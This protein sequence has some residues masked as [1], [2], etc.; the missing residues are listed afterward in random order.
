MKS[1]T[2]L[3]FLPAFTHLFTALFD[4]VETKRLRLEK[5]TYYGYNIDEGEVMNLSVR[6]KLVCFALKR[7][8]SLNPD[9]NSSAAKTIAGLDRRTAGRKI[10][11]HL[12]CISDVTANGTKYKRISLRNSAP[13]G[14]AVYYLH[15][16]A[17]V[18]GLNPFYLE[19]SS[20]L[21]EANGG[22]EV[23]F[24]DYS[25]APE[26]QYPTQLEQAFDLWSEIVN[27]FGYEPQNV[28]I[29]GDSAGGNLTLALMVKLRDEN[30]AM[31]KGGFCISPWADMTASGKSYFYNYKRD[32]LFGDRKKDANDELRKKLAQSDIFDYASKLSDEQRRDPLVSPVFASYHGFPPMFFAVGSDEMLLCDTLKIAKKLK[33][34]NCCVTLEVGEGMFHIY[35][36]FYRYLPEAKKSFKRLKEFLKEL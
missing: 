29:G 26:H 35:A 28:V 5:F 1:H 2:F 14:R 9:K 30:M 17:F 31:P 3:L 12:E 11:S 15:G 33:K 27:V 6:G 18:A 7:Y 13:N 36:L 34:A 10:S 20:E 21:I 25:T 22:G 16:G 4:L 19:L 8:V 32:V 23:V 24:L